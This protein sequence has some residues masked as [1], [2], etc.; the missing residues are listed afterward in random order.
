MATVPLD[1]ARHELIVTRAPAPESVLLE[2]VDDVFLP[3]VQR[4]RR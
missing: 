4:R 3:L 2:I 1:L